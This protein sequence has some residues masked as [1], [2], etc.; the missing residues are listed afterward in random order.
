MAATG[1]LLYNIIIIFTLATAIL[2]LCSR[3]RIPNIIGF[4]LTGMVAGPHALGLIHETGEVQAIAEIGIILLL[5]TIGMEFSF[6]K[7]L[8]IKRPALLGGTLQVVLTTGAVLFIGNLAGLSPSRSLFIGFLVSLSSTAIVLNLLQERSEMESPQGRTML[9][10]LI[11]Q[12]LAIIPMILITPMLSGAADTGSTSL[13]VFFAMSVGIIAFVMISARWAVPAILFQAARL[14][15][16]EIFLLCIVL[17]CL[18]TAWLT[19]YAG[20]SLSL[21]AFLAG[22]I[23]AD[24]EYSHDALGAIL[25]LKEIFT[26]FFFVSVGMLLNISFFLSNPLL[27][28]AIAAGVILIKAVVAGTTA[29]IIGH[30]FRTAILVGLGMAQVGEFSFILSEV[31]REYGLLDDMMYQA[32]LVVTILSMLATPF[33]IQASPKV[34]DAAMRLSIPERLRHGTIAETP[35]SEKVLRQHIIIVGFGLGG[36]NVAKAAKSA[37]IPYVVTEMNPETVREEREKGEHIHY[38]DATRSQVLLHAGIRTAKVLLVVI[39]DPIATRRIISQARRENPH[40]HIITRTRY[41]GEIAELADLGADEVISEEYVTSIETFTRILSAY[42]VP[43]NEIDRFASEIRA[44]NYELF[45]K[46]EARMPTLR[47]IGFYRPGTG[48]ETLRVDE[49]AEIEGISLAEADLRKS[50][51]VTVLAI[52]RG[53]EVIAGPSGSEVIR[54]GDICVVIGPEERIAGVSSVF[55]GLEKR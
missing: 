23:I 39:S 35:V 4:L 28:I 18:F 10:I 26:S 51:G 38:G 3:L 43:K 24:S 29:V 37:G 49:G 27:I 1:I 41:V 30:S 17:I 21:G 5:F 42:L 31:G 20:L 40:L 52:R 15:N 55:C 16:R 12:D 14:R 45:R 6:Q 50:H 53:E 47:D 44:A 9:G 22:L 2:F 36:R 25:P 54:A 19:E 48:L 46:P 8:Q 13:P 34:A 32:F 33:L 7:L 11:F